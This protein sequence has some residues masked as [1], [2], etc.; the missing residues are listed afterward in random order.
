[1]RGGISSG[2][3]KD[4]AP[5]QELVYE[6]S[7]ESYKESTAVY[8]VNEEASPYY[9]VMYVSVLDVNGN[10]GDSGTVYSFKDKNDPENAWSVTGLEIGAIEAE[11]VPG[12]D[13]AILFHGDV[14]RDGENLEFIAVLPDGNYKLRK[15]VGT[16]ISN[17]MSTFVVQTAEGSTVSFLKD[18][19]RIEDGAMNRDSGDLVIV[20]YAD[21]GELGK[22]P[23]RI[24][25]GT[26]KA[27]K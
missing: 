24:Y 1:M 9:G 17:T 25:A 12:A 19:C 11:L 23:M 8:G 4:T 20:Y 10:P 3:E 14:I 18:N 7:G 2:D 22:F 6:D 26:S 27:G 21:G 16:T 15:T 5:A 13:V